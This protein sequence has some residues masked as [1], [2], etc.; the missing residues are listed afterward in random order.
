MLEPKALALTPLALLTL[1][2]T[3]HAAQPRTYQV[4]GPVTALT[5]DTLTI[6]KGRDLW[7][8]GRDSGTKVIGDL[9]VG[10]KVTVQ[11]RMSAT[12]IEVKPE[13]AKGAKPAAKKK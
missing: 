10:D 2:G 4:T 5:S 12:E 3:L 11:Y 7:E 6:Q 1:A 13:A 9:K 8:I